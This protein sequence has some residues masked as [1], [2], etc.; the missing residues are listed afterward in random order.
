MTALKRKKGEIAMSSNLS[1]LT[2]PYLV[3]RALH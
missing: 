1:Q 2:H 3:E